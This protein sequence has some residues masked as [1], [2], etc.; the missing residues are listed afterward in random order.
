[1]PRAATPSLHPVRR[2]SLSDAVFEQLR[3]QIVRGER[4]PGSALPAERAL[5]EALGVNRGAVR[6]ALRRLEQAR[7][8]AVRQGGISR[9]L[10]YR[11]SAGLELLGALLV[12]AGG[13]FDPDVVRGILEMRSALGPDVARLAA[14]RGGAACAEALERRIAALAAADGDL[15]ALQEAASG[16]WSQLVEGAD[17]VAYRLAYNAMNETYDR[18]RELLA[19]ALAP[20]LGDVAAYAAIA[21]AVRRADAAEAETLARALLRRGEAGVLAALERA[22]ALEQGAS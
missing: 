14:L 22:R 17:N 19:R 6:E 21:A 7:L 1:M 8:V 10:D 5:C 4:V 16:F 3:D 20:E 11:E 18:C 15:A 13:R 9:V 2:Q 12:D